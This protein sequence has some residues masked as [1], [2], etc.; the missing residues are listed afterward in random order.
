MTARGAVCFSAAIDGEKVTY[1]LM[2]GSIQN[3]FK[4]KIV[5]DKEEE[6]A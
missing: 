5:I 2:P 1:N 6:E 3:I 4:A